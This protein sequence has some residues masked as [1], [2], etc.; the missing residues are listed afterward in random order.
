MLVKGAT[1]IIDRGWIRA[2]ERS[3]FSVMALRVICL[4]NRL[5]RVV[6]IVFHLRVLWY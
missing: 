4:F 2:T 5:K 3:Q 6:N 1:A